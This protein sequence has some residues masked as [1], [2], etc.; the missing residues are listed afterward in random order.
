MWR[1]GRPHRRRQST[2]RGDATAKSP[3]P[4][5]GEASSPLH[6]KDSV[7]VDARVGPS[8][9]ERRFDPLVLADRCGSGRRGRAKRL[10]GR[11]DE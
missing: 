8:R 6:P 5:Q 2:R 7:Q 10:N 1:R 4:R 3:G 11:R 9:L